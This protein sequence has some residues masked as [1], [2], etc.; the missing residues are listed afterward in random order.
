MGL[1]NVLR[2]PYTLK[3]FKSS[4]LMSKVFWYLNLVAIVFITFF[5]K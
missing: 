1:Q 5:E 2:G 3:L 4:K